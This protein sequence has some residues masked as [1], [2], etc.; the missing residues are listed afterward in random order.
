M[1]GRPGGRSSLGLY[2]RGLFVVFAQ[3]AVELELVGVLVL[4]L[5]GQERADRIAAQN[6]GEQPD[7][8]VLSP[9]ELAL[10]RRQDEIL[11][12]NALDAASAI[13]IG[14]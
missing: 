14:D 8:L 4:D 1:T 6:A 5:P 11:A 9:D 2:R 7:D 3:E 13:V 12:L 10:D